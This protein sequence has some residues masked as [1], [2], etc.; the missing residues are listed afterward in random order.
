MA[1]FFLFGIF[2]Y[3]ALVVAVGGAIWRYTR[4]QF[5]FSSLSSQFLEGR[6]L[7]WGSVAWHYGIIAILIGHFIGIFFPSGVKAFN[8]VPVRLYLL[9]GTALALGLLLLVGLTL[10]IVRRGVNP[11]IRT[12][13]SPMDITLLAFLAFQVLTGVGIAIFYRWGSAWFV[14]TAAPYFWSLAKLSPQVEY[15]ASLPLLVKI[16]AAS[17]FTLVALIPF[18]RLVHMLAIPIGYLWR[19]YQRVMWYSRVLQK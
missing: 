11:R 16:H 3:V 14:D 15:M 8:S 4:N 2:P 7:F 12:M 17:A 13:T 19:P 6:Q 5:T 1:D 9:E 18:T 10:L